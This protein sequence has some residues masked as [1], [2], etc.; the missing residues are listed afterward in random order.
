MIRSEELLRSEYF[1]L[2]MGW[3]QSDGGHFRQGFVGTRKIFPLYGQRASEAG[4]KPLTSTTAPVNGLSTCWPSL[5]L[6]HRATG[7]DSCLGAAGEV[8]GT[9]VTEESL[10]QWVELSR[11]QCSD[12]ILVYLSGDRQALGLLELPNGHLATGTNHATNRPVIE[13]Q[14]GKFSLHHH[15]EIKR[16]RLIVFRFDATI[17]IIVRNPAIIRISIVL[18]IPTWAVAKPEEPGVRKKTAVTIEKSIIQGAPGIGERV[19]VALCLDRCHD[20]DNGRHWRET[21]NTVAPFHA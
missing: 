21:I 8:D 9:G 2:P 1:T 10:G 20:Q 11:P 12:Q 15:G 4:G 19:K 5:P 6:T 7:G 13:T 14:T 17:E 16:I 3:L 18:W